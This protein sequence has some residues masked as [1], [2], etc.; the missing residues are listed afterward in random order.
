MQMMSKDIFSKLRELEKVQPWI[1]DRFDRF[2]V[3]LFSDCKELCQ[4]GL[5]FELLHR[6]EFVP[7]QRYKEIIKCLALDIMTDPDLSDSET[8]IVALAADSGA[9]SSHYVLSDLKFLMDELGWK[10]HKF[11]NTFGKAYKAYVKSTSHRNIVLV[12]EFVGSGQTVLNRVTAIS[13]VF[14]EHDVEDYTIRVKVLVSTEHAYERLIEEGINITAQLFIKKGISDY[15]TEE[16][17]Y[18]K[19]EI[20][21]QLESILKDSIDGI[22][23]PSLGYN[24]A[25]SLYYRDDSNVPN[26]VFPI[27]WWPAYKD[28]RDRKPLLTR[29]NG[30][31]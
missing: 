10:K 5:L 16:D 12:D 17:K 28:G 8:Q 20:M 6:F 9:D 14:E 18:N 1:T 29:A 15:Y 27:F 26:S 3:L 24:A 21:L 11:V 31:L 7:H 4:Q 13:K 30:D 25:E 22:Q 2:E 19:T 23:L